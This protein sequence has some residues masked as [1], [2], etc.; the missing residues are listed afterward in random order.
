MY[1]ILTSITEFAEKDD[2]N[3]LMEKNPIMTAME[4][5]RRTDRGT[6]VGVQQQDSKV[7]EFLEAVQSE[8]EESKNRKQVLKEI[9]I[10][11]ADKWNSAKAK[12]FVGQ[13]KV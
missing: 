6:D 2:R 4:N 13:P 5:S 11:N 1:I 3:D 12:D 9:Y 10:R 8:C 7:N